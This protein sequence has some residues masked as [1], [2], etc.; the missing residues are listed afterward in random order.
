MRE[1]YVRDKES[2]GREWVKEEKKQGRVEIR[3]VRIGG[4]GG[5]DWGGCEDRSGRR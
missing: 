1:E 3:G 2:E 5:E 4:I